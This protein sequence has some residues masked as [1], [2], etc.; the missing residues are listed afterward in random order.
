MKMKMIRWNDEDATEE[1]EED[2]DDKKQQRREMSRTYQLDTIPTNNALLLR[3][4]TY[5]TC[6]LWE[7][8]RAE[9]EKAKAE[10]EAEAKAEMAVT[11]PRVMIIR[12]LHRNKVI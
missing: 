5:L 9:R 1:E 8:E 6:D 12:S 4:P 2:D 3:P 11:C 10:A 7:A